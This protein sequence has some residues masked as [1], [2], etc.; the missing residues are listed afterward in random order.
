MM[1]DRLKKILNLVKEGKITPQEAD[2]LISALYENEEQ[3]SEKCYFTV[4]II[5]GDG[6]LVNIKLPIKF[7]KFMVKATGKLSFDIQDDSLKNYFNSKGIKID[8]DGK[9]VDF[10]SFSKAIDELCKEKPSEIVNIV[11]DD[12]KEGSVQ[13]KVSVE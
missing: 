5:K 1:E 13:I 3:M 10:T 12:E 9:I 6:K 2:N 8:K 4:K 11:A 7:I